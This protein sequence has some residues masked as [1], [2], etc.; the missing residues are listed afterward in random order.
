MSQNL[1]PENFA[2]C[3]LPIT[4]HD[5][6]QLS[7]GSGGKMMNNLI[8]KLFLWAFDNPTLNKLDDQAVLELN[9]QRLAFSTDSFVVDPLFFPGGDI[10]E[11]AV[12]G[13]V[14][15]VCM[16]GARPLFLSAGFII[17]E[18][19]SLEELKT[20]VESMKRAAEKAGVMIVTG[21]TKVVNKGKGD[22]VFINTTGI[23]LIDGNCN[24]SSQNLQPG[25]MLILSGSPVDAQQPDS[26]HHRLIR[27]VLAGAG[28]AVVSVN[29]TADTT[30][31]QPSPTGVSTSTHFTLESGYW[32]ALCS[33]D[34]DRDGMPDWWEI[35]NGLDPAVNDAG[36]DPD[37]DGLTNLQEYQNFTDPQSA[38]SD[39]DGM[40]DGWEVDNGLDPTADDASQDADGDGLTNLEE[41]QNGTDPNDPDT[42]GDGLNDGDEVNVYHTDPRDADSDSDGLSDGDEVNVY[43]TDPNDA[44]SDGDGASDGDAVD[45][46]SDP[47]DP[48]SHPS[49]LVYLPLA[50]KSYAPPAPAPGDAYEVDDTCSQANDIAVD[51]TAQHHDFFVAHDKDWLRFPAVAGRAYVIQ[52]FNLGPDADTILEL[53][54]PNCGVLLTS[55]DDGG[56]GYASRI[57]YV[58]G[59]SD[60]YYVRVKP[61]D[62]SV[63]GAGTSY[64]VAVWESLTGAASAPWPA[65]VGDEGP[66]PPAP[67]E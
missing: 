67:E 55:D 34:T 43:H 23:G 2:Q 29:H 15:D 56:D 50:L 45:Q 13:T 8:S 35:A 60:T 4:A 3:P 16:S 22:K 47:N 1:K 21:D 10:G 38:D 19:F 27:C 58:V 48:N 9:G 25:D 37:G 5:T 28:P 52:T 32:P 33:L 42:D 54:A 20:I 31:G 17:E 62:W 14:N 24:L 49:Y 7:H 64:D 66:K 46:G 36:D 61:Y 59:S 53:Y 51:G 44:D 39:G 57:E 6:V 18:G 40:P 26:D 65:A 30:L 63:T 12:N 41:H 11:L